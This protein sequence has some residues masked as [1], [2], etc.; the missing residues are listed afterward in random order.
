MSDTIADV[1]AS[2]FARQFY[3][4][5]ASAQ[6]VGVALAQAKV[7]MEIAQLDDAELPEAIARD[8]VDIDDLVLVRPPLYGTIAGAQHLE[9]VASSRGCQRAAPR[10]GPSVG[11]PPELPHQP[12]TCASTLAQLRQK[13]EPEPSRPRHLI[14]EPGMGYRFESTIG[15]P[16]P[17]TDR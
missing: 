17:R 14:T 10:A 8:D 15:A 5:I 7:A 1:S 3:A 2:V 6:T 12:T 16:Q 9:F 13:L 4:A 11:P